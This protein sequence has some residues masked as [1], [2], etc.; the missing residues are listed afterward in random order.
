VVDAIK[1][2]GG[3][4][5]AMEEKIGTMM[6]ISTAAGGRKSAVRLRAANVNGTYCE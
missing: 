1:T 4:K 2:A 6:K 3:K 5:P